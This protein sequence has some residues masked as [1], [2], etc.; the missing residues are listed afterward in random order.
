ML[1]SE[2]GQE[3]I[4][5]VQ[6][7]VLRDVIYQQA[8]GARRRVIHRQVARWLRFRGQLAEAALHFARSAD[9]GDD[10]AVDVLLDA[11]RQAE[12]REAFLEA[13]DLQAELV[14]LLPRPMRAG[15]RFS[16]RCTGARSG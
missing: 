8:G 16:R 12:Q 13:L 5:E 11:I 10:E 6:R 2:R 1:E 3:L 15:S 9:P 14:D 4:Y 7:P